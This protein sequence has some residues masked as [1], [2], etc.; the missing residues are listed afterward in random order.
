[1]QPYF[2][3]GNEA[4]IAI[5]K[6]LYRRM[7]KAQWRKANR[8]VI[9]EITVQLTKEEYQQ[10]KDEAK[11]HKE[12]IT[13][14]IKIATLGYMDKCYVVPN[15]ETIHQLLV[16][17]TLCYNRLEELLEE[18]KLTPQV[19]KELRQTIETLER[20][21][22]VMILAPKTIEQTLQECLQNNSYKKNYLLT[23]I[24]QLG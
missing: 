8:K 14:F 1:M 10:I 5:G 12:S 4:E 16:V 7:Y 21:V 13:R 22:R 11:K 9:K 19:E 6:I 18:E 17:F 3:R 23:Y 24:Q 15:N 20:E 2:E